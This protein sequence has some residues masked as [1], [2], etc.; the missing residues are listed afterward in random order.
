MLASGTNRAQT[1]VMPCEFEDLAVR[2][3][4]LVETAWP[5]ITEA[6]SLASGERSGCAPTQVEVPKEAGE[7][8]IF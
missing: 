5:R 1:L 6:C 4:T 3:R 2:N 8:L 7:C